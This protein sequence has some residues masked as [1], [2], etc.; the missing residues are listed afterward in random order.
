[1]T[2]VF[3]TGA[4]GYIG[5]DALF[6]LY[7]KHPDFAFSVL[8]RDAN[9]T[10][11]IE[12]AFPGIRI[13]VGG[14]DDFELLEKEAADAD[15]VVHTADAS[16][17]K[18]AANAIAAGLA[19]GHS[20]SHPG[21]WLHTG[22]TGI[23]TFADSDRQVYGEYDS[24]VYND[25]EGVDELTHLPAHAFHRNIDEI[26]LE[27][28]T[29]YADKVKTALLC[30]PTIYGPG[31]GPVHQR[32]RQVYTL[33]RTTLKNRQAP[34]LGAGKSVW[35]NVHVHDLSNLFVLLA[36]AAI[37]GNHADGIW[38]ANGYYLVENGEHV[39]GD[40]SHAVAAEAAAQGYIPEAKVE[41]VDFQTALVYGGY[42][43]ASWGMNSRGTA[44]RAAK[45][46]GWKPVGKSLLDELP[47]IVRGE[48]EWSKQ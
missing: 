14:L 44:K 6:A 12:A 18:V 3:L 29:K 41:H 2:K 16:D 32:S 26:V 20:P 31:R 17:H 35:N 23:L 15:I 19:K 48:Y 36:E 24:K 39:W 11:A 40:I 38:G 8:V 43:S 25:W 7:S 1:M 5:G 9:K 33:A 22:G 30:P 10:G 28:G 45:L 27:T 46:L 4:T 47:G 42:E 37:A 21:Y 34:I 13:V